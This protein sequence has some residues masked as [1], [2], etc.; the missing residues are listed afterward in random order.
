MQGMNPMLTGMSQMSAFQ[1]P[2]ATGGSGWGPGSPGGW[3]M[4]GGMGMPGGAW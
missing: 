3:P 4:G 1:A 2:M